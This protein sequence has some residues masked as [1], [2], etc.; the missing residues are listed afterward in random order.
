MASVRLPINGSTLR[1]AREIGRLQEGELGRSCGVTIEKVQ[2]FESGSAFPTYNQMKRLAKKLDRPVTFFFA[3]PPL[4]PDVPTTV[5]FRGRSGDISPLLAREMKRAIVQ[6]SRILDLEGP[7][8]PVEFPTLNRESVS[9]AALEF[10]GA[11]GLGLADVPRT[12]AAS[13]TFSYWRRKLEDLGVLVFQTT[14]V[15]LSDFR[16]LSVAN[17]VLPVILLNGSDSPLGKVFTLFHEIGHLATRTSGMCLLDDSVQAE[18][19]CNA[20]A[21]EFLLPLASVR[22]LKLPADPIQAVEA[23]SRHF[24]VSRLAAAVRLR[25]LRLIGQADLDAVKARTDED[26][27]ASRE[28]LKQSDSVPPRHVLRYRDL[29]R[30]YVGT[31]AR[32]LETE[33]ISTLDAT[34]LLNAKAVTVQKILEEYFRDAGAH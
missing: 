14:G 1:W 4:T 9:K 20:F 15:A 22:E 27:A 10:R 28:K 34:Y 25:G 26:W 7:G 30:K 33:R 17:D 29:G 24:R 23:M 2:A 12:G 3:G 32:A 19:L 18:T 13:Q 6:R 31:V 16:G 11:L 21:Q 5:D 8:R